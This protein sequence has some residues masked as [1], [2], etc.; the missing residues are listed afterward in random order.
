M[1]HFDQIQRRET[2]ETQMAH[3]DSGKDGVGLPA[4]F[5][6]ESEIVWGVRY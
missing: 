4:E 6:L 5:E 2:P 3:N 1:K